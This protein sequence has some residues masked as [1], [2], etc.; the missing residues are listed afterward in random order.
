[1][2]NHPSFVVETMVKAVSF[3]LWFTLIW[4][5]H[6]ED[7]EL[8]TR[9]RAGA[10]AEILKSRGFET[11]IE[12]IIKLYRSL[13]PARMLL[14]NKETV[15]L[16]L[17]GLGIE[18][19]DYLVNAV[20]EAYEYSTDSFKPRENPEA[21]KILDLLKSVGVKIAIVS[22][23]SFSARSIRA[24]LKNIEIS[25]Y[26]DTIISSSDV[27]YLKPKKQI[28]QSLLKTLGIEASGVIHVGDSC[29]DDILGA[30]SSG[31]KAAYYTGLLHL[32]K[33]EPDSVCLFL[34]PTIRSLDELIKYIA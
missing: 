20:T 19:D 22:N 32:R 30:L 21:L 4:E 18:S 1:M 14:S 11:S 23:T 12:K 3:D 13:G 7:E 17:T 5:K 28:F 25:D 16:I 31:I 2:P 9:L 24:I 26:I 33:A 10:I 29:V 27:G 15:S 6:P 34:A 8:Y